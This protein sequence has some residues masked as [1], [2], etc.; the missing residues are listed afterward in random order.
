MS[1]LKDGRVVKVEMVV[2]KG[3]EAGRKEG[4]WACWGR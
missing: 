3:T 2:Q 4:G 1:W